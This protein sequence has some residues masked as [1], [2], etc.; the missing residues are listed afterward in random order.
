MQQPV[1]PEP[2]VPGLLTPSAPA[3]PNFRPQKM[4]GVNE[5]QID[6]GAMSSKQTKKT[7]SVEPVY[8]Y[9]LVPFVPDAFDTVLFAA[10]VRRLWRAR[11]A[12]TVLRH[13]LIM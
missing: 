9:Q 12:C 13:R 8:D 11:R 6:Y 10:A 7:I 2:A 4:Q 3:A 1:P 5:E